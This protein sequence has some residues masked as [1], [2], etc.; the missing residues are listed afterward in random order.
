MN[1][2]EPRRPR[3]GFSAGHETPYGF[4]G[5]N[6]ANSAQ[7]SVPSD[8]SC[9]IVRL[10]SLTLGPPAPRS[11][12]LHP[13]ISNRLECGPSNRVSNGI[14]QSAISAAAQAAR[15]IPGCQ[16]AATGSRPPKPTAEPMRRSTPLRRSRKAEH[17]WAIF[18]GSKR[19]KTRPSPIVGRVPS[20]TP[21]SLTRR[22][23]DQFFTV[24]FEVTPVTPLV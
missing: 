4:A 2:V 17:S 8:A 5:A 3:C 20:A 13:W 7:A 1:F 15:L 19:L 12:R 11:V 14:P 22:N 6:G 9:A 24:S 16:Q 23:R 18:C 21:A 10:N